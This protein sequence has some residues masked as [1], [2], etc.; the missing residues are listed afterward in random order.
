MP[1][2][3]IRFEVVDNPTR[4][5]RLT[6]YLG[7]DRAHAQAIRT[8]Y[9]HGSIDVHDIDEEANDF[10]EALIEQGLGQLLCPPPKRLS[11]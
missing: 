7:R 1:K 4:V 9:K 10:R 3:P 6:L 11:D 8:I 5:S 2:F